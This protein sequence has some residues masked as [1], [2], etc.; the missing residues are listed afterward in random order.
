MKK[1]LQKLRTDSENYSQHYL[2]IIEIDG[3]FYSGYFHI[4]KHGE[5]KTFYEM[6]RGYGENLYFAWFDDYSEAESYILS[7]ISQ[8]KF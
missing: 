1:V 4:T 3:K 2:E 6:E 8:E 5:V 7:I